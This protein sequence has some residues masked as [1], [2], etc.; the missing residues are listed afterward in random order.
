VKDDKDVT[1]RGSNITFGNL[2]KIE[3]ETK[4]IVVFGLIQFVLDVSYNLGCSLECNRFTYGV[5]FLHPIK[6][7]GKF[8]SE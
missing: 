1:K 7:F 2:K 5:Y 8:F 3:R 6:V 4:K